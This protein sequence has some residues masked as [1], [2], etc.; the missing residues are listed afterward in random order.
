[1]A[2][3]QWGSTGGAWNYQQ[4][5]VNTINAIKAWFTYPDGRVN[6]RQG[7]A[8]R[9][10]TSDFMF[11]HFRAFRQATND[12]HWDTVI[13]RQ[14]TMLETVIANHSP[15]AGL[16]PDFL[17]NTDTTPVPGLLDSYPSSCTPGQGLGD[18]TISDNWYF[19]N[20]QRNPWRYGTDYVLSGDARVRAI[21]VRMMNFFNADM[22][23]DPNNAATGY[24]L[25]GTLD[26]CLFRPSPNWARGMI[27]PMLAGATVDASLQNFLN[28]LWAW[29]RDNFATNYYDSELQLI[30]MIV[31]SGNWWAPTPS[32]NPPPP[33]PPPPPTGTRIEAENGM[34]QGSGVSVK[35]DVA[36]FQGS[37]FVGNFSN[38]GDSLAVTFG[39]VQ[40]GTYQVRI[41]YHAWTAQENTVSINGTARTVQFPATHPNW[42]EAVITGVQLAAGSNTVVITKDWGW[43]NVDAIEIVQTSGSGSGGSGGTP[44]TIQVQAEGGS[45]SGSGVSV[46]TDVAGYQGS[47]FVGSFSANGDTLT[48]PFSNVVAGT[49]NLRIRYHAWTAQE[50]TV[51]VNG[52]PR[53]VQFPATHPGW[54]VATVPG[55]ALPAGNS[56]V[57]ISK[58]WGWINVDWVEIAP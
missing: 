26:P 50:N 55:I 16:Q 46:K 22:G 15:N 10:R 29:N 12:P 38:N 36:G 5:A 9:A 44:V 48:I 42:S 31:A 11:Q 19:A 52:T 35:T 23:G 49:Y 32:G 51:S 3:R 37:G 58:D 21:L 30:P 1:M 57:T 24:K 41:R 28:A 39:N 53:T 25:D 17:K 8:N 6:L 56:T 45:L 13:S 7:G 54:A 40:A 18:W 33:P 20:A 47:A 43:I 2:H 4:E 14:L 27:G 34:L